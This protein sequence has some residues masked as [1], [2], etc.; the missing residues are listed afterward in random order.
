MS[1]IFSY[2][3]MLQSKSLDFSLPLAYLFPG[4]VRGEKKVN[5]NKKEYEP[6]KVES[7]RVKNKKCRRE[8][9]K[10]EEI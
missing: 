8:R 1:E 5:E 9:K 4:Q 10:R 7:E 6:L 3:A 2:V